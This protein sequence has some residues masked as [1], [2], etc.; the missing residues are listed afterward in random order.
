MKTKTID[1]IISDFK[2]QLS[3]FVM[4]ENSVITTSHADILLADIKS[5]METREFSAYQE[6]YDC[7]VKECLRVSLKLIPHHGNVNDMFKT[8]GR[9]RSD[10]LTKEDL[11]KQK[12]YNKELKDKRN[13]E[14]TGC[15]ICTETTC[16]RPKQHLT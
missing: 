13:E 11:E 2:I 7:G 8:K 10:G 6:G 5:T 3:D 15:N 9:E 12:R 1:D 16:Q 14:Y 4:I